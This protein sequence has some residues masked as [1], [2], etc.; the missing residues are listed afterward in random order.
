[1]RNIKY[2]IIIPVYNSGDWLEELVKGVAEVIETECKC[3]EIIL[4]NDGSPKF[5]TWSIMCGLTVKYKNLVAINLS[6]NSGQQ[7]AIMCGLR[8]A[9]G[10]YIITMD[11]DFQHSPS[12][13]LSLI[14]KINSADADVVIAQ[15][16]VKEHSLIRRVGSSIVNG[17]H[18][19]IYHKP[20]DVTSNSYRIMKKWVADTISMYNGKSPQIGPLIFSIRP[21]IATIMIKHE[22]RKYGNSGY[23]PFRLIS[24]TFNI[25]LNGST[26]YVDCVASFGFA[27]SFISI[28]LIIYYLLKYAIGGIGVKG[29]TSQM[30]LM[31]FSLGIITMSIGIVG[32]YIGKI[33]KET[34]GYPPYFE[35]EIR[36]SAEEEK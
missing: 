7:N 24:E 34:S 18:T 27:I 5:E 9:N 1:M 12:Y 4:V 6:Y 17:I 21:Q 11:D 28:V 19:K 35:R 20:K 36:S 23:S 32:K 15:Y 26:F 13:I 14:D 29:Y 30:I 2:S 22:K 10:D 31:I 25:I 3:Y 33:I 8:H 16:E